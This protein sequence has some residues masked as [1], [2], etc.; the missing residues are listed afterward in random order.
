MAR[1]SPDVVESVKAD[2]A[3]GSDWASEVRDFGEDAVVR[4]A[5]R[6]GLDAGD[7]RAGGLGLYG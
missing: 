1:F 3:Q 5:A 4:C 7:Q 6:D 2:F